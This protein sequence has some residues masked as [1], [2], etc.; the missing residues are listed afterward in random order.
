MRRRDILRLWA[1]IVQHTGIEKY[2]AE[3]WQEH[4][5]DFWKCMQTNENPYIRVESI[6][7]MLKDDVSIK[8]VQQIQRTKRNNETRI[9]NDELEPQSVLRKRLKLEADNMLLMQKSNESKVTPG[10]KCTRKRNTNDKIE[11]HIPKSN[12]TIVDEPMTSSKLQDKKARNRV[13]V[14]NRDNLPKDQVIDK[15]EFS[16]KK[17]TNNNCTT[18][19]QSDSPEKWNL[20]KEQ[21]SDEEQET[22]NEQREQ[23]QLEE[24][25]SHLEAELEQLYEAETQPEKPMIQTKNSNKEKK[26]KKLVD[27]PEDEQRKQEIVRIK[28]QKVQDKLIDEV[29][30]DN[31]KQVDEQEFLNKLEHEIWIS[32][33]DQGSL[34]IEEKKD[35]NVSMQDNTKQINVEKCQESKQQKL[36]TPQEVEESISFSKSVKEKKNQK[37]LIEPE[38]EPEQIVTNIKE[39]KNNL[40]NSL[41]ELSVQNLSKKAEEQL[42]SIN[43]S[44]SAEPE[45]NKKL[46]ETRYGMRTRSQYVEKQE[47]NRANQEQQQVNPNKRKPRSS[48][49]SNAVNLICVTLEF[50]PP[51]QFFLLPQINEQMAHM[52]EKAIDMSPTSHAAYTAAPVTEKDSSSIEPENLSITQLSND[53]ETPK[54][55]DSVTLNQTD[56]FEFS[57]PD[58]TYSKANCELEDKLIKEVMEL[59]VPSGGSTDISQ[60]LTDVGKCEMFQSGVEEIDRCLEVFI[61]KT[62]SEIDHQIA[63][64]SEFFDNLPSLS[65]LVDKTPLEMEVLLNDTLNY[66]VDVEDDDDNDAISVTTSWDGDD[67]LPVPNPVLS[68]KESTIGEQPEM[69]NSAAKTDPATQSRESLSYRILKGTYTQTEKL[70]PHKEQVQSTQTVVD[71]EKMELQQPAPQQKKQTRPQPRNE[72]VIQAEAPLDVQPNQSAV[73]REKMELQQSSPQPKQLLQ[74]QQCQERR[75][76]SLPRLKFIPLHRTIRQ[77]S[78]PT[79]EANKVPLFGPLYRVP[80]EPASTAQSAIPNECKYFIFGIKCWAYLDGRCQDSNCNHR[81]ASPWEVQRKLNQMTTDKLCDTYSMVLRHGMLFRNYFIIFAEIYGNRGMMSYLMKMVEDCGLYMAYS[82]PYITEL[83]C[84]LMRYD[85]MPQIATDHIMKHLWGPEIGQIYPEFAMQ[86]L[87]ILASADWFNYVPQL[88]HLFENQKFPIPGEFMICLTNDAIAKKDNALVRKV[89]E[90][91]LFCPINRNDVTLTSVVQIVNDWCLSNPSTMLPQQL[92]QQPN[93]PSQEKEQPQ[94]LKRR[95]NNS[96]QRKRGR[97]NSANR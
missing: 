9:D 47:P 1:Q 73:D 92:E 3:E 11:D 82:A 94:N 85:L 72:Q 52:P 16:I 59:A 22:L 90:M 77:D 12:T 23:L 67:Q 17:L 48:R 24:E 5:E 30:L 78:L 6:D 44:T 21:L 93:H 19:V 95:F 33:E 32:K 75:Q 13:S 42:D 58:S 57:K 81:L 76:Q 37:Q 15:A 63:D 50:S 26:N 87:R 31:E 60:L 83:Y 71:R 46:T 4:Y 35:K 88:K 29:E 34:K 38:P 43:L 69:I 41:V 45:L 96:G 86:L 28:K 14:S 61:N 36:Q 39:S 89:W 56:S 54:S 84:I 25:I 62:P 74:Q 10:M 97:N 91:M 18:N 40:K 55:D 8:P 2:T 66:D 51:N 80:L 49:K 68:E 79:E 7:L 65:T 64:T 20:P 27:E 53:I 70:Q